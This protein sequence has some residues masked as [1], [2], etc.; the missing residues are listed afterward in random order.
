[1]NKYIENEIK[2]MKKV[3]LVAFAYN[4]Y[5]EK[6]HLEKEYDELLVYKN[7]LRDRQRAKIRQENKEMNAWLEALPLI[8]KDDPKWK[9]LNLEP[10]NLVV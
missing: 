5:I 9:H 10:D 3:E 4:L 7:Q 6:E 8:K 2:K 1:M